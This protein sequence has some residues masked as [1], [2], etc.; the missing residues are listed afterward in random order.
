MNLFRPLSATA[1]VCLT[2]AGLNGC[3]SAPDYDIV[4][5]IEF[6][7]LTVGRNR[8]GGG[9]LATDTLKFAVNYKDG[10]G[11][12]GLSS[13]D[14][15]N[16]PY[17]SR[18]GGPS[19]RGFSYNYFIQ[20]YLQ[21]SNGRFV[22]YNPGGVPGEYDGTYPRLEK[23]LNPDAKPGPI[24][25]TLRYKLPI[26]LDGVIFKSGQVFRAEISIMDR[27]LHQSNK[28]TTSEVTLGQ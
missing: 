12:L 5:E 10:D 22:A 15:R 3:I 23:N 7:E 20:L 28:V 9:N 18:T 4:P 17:N 26:S 11:D 24:R 6:N 2:A 1:L 8:P 13:N 27:A 19:G 14:I 21:E 25:G 16:A